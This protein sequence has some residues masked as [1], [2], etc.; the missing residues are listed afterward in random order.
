M[1]S[2]MGIEFKLSLCEVAIGRRDP[3]CFVVQGGGSQ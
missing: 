3:S 1:G 2:G